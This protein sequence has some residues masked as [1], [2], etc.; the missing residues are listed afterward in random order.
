M[1]SDSFEDS[2]KLTKE[3]ARYQSTPGR[4]MAPK[5]RRKSAI[6]QQKPKLDPHHTPP[7]T[8]RFSFLS[9]FFGRTEFTK[10]SPEAVGPEKK[11]KKQRRHSV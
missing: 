11:A 10:I 3:A 5:E 6:K 4:V 8:R 9:Y 1:D 7:K 2:I